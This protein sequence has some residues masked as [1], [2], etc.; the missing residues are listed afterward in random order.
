MASSTVPGPKYSGLHFDVSNGRLDFY[1]QGTRVGHIN[2]SGLL[3]AVGSLATG[4]IPL[5]L[6]AWRLIASSD[7]AAKNAADGGLISLD[8]DPTLKNV[9]AGTDKNMRIAWAANSVVPITIGFAYPPDL[10]DTAAVT[11]NL[12]TGKGTNTNTTFVIGVAYFEGVGDT[13]AGGNTS[14]LNETTG[15]NLHTVTIAA[16]DVG[17]YPQSAVVELTPAAH[18]NDA[19]YLYGAFLSYVRKI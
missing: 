3:T 12:I 10:D 9:N 8:T 13:N 5:P 11:V 16:S 4:Y 17:A 7:I 2:A 1:Y 6:T 18:A 19:V 15:Q 14:A